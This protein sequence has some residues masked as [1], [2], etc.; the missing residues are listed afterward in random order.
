MPE[1]PRTSTEHLVRAWYDRFNAGDR[2]GMLALLAE[3]VA[4]EINQGA[5]E[6]G[7]PAFA[8]FLARMDRAYAERVEDLVVMT[9][10]DGARAAAEFTVHGTYLATDAGLPAAA[11]QRYTL[12][13]GAFF[14]IAGGRIARIA[15]HYNLAA[16]IRMV[17]G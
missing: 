8:T 6:T 17:G 3:D 15:T 4:H 2:P 12:P 11:G 16:W 10:A 5:T 7:I 9:A 13:A 14:T 1:T